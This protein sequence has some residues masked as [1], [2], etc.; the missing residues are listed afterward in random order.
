MSSA[1]RDFPGEDYAPP[2]SVVIAGR[3]VKAGDSVLLRP[4]RGRQGTLTDAMDMMLDG[5]TA[6]VEVLQQDFENRIYLVVTLD[7]DPGR[8]QWDE[9][10][11]PGH[12]FFFFPEEVEPLAES[13]EGTV[14]HESELEHSLQPKI[15]VRRILIACIG[16][17]FLGD[18]SFGVEVAQSLMSRKTKRYPEGVQVVDFGIGGIDLAYTL[19]DNY[20]TLVLV[21]AVSRGGTPGTLYLIEPDLA[22]IDPEKGVEAGRAA[23]EAHSMDPLK[24]LAFARTLGAQPIHTF[25]V[26]CEPA[27]LNE[28]EEH[29]AMQMG[30]SEPV[31]ASIDEA[32]KMIDSLVDTLLAIKM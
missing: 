9:R 7:V 10:V 15:P 5:K 31:R 25:L 28:S 1:N 3:M 13:M 4:G 14:K 21:D 8:E 2:E 30:L 29:A 12:R 16:N 22:G 19:L 17:I 24:V 23:M 11:L 20:D 18:D 26:G 32:V 27:P 6:R